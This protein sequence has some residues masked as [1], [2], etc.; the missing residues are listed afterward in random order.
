MSPST[1]LR[2]VF[3]LFHFWSSTLSCLYER[4][5]KSTHKRQTWCGDSSFNCDVLIWFVQLII[6]NS[7][8]LAVFASISTTFVLFIFFLFTF[9]FTAMLACRQAI[10]PRNDRNWTSIDVF[11]ISLQ[12]SLNAFRLSIR[13][14]WH[15]FWWGSC[16]DLFEICIQTH[17]L[18]C[19]CG[20]CLIVRQ[21]VNLLPWPI[22]RLVAYLK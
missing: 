22:Y 14:D 1:S 2:K 7:I 21:L 5:D 8:V 10:Q 4:P 17:V 12:T 11:P 19:V 9:H 6:Y 13:R 18:E 16:Q 20:T 3:L 15:P